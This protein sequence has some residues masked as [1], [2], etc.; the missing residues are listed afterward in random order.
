MWRDDHQPRDADDA[1]EGRARPSSTRG[2]CSCRSSRTSGPAQIEVGLYSRQVGPASCRSTARTTGDAIDPGR[3]L[4]HAAARKRTVHRLS[5]TAGTRRRSRERPG[6]EWQWS[7]K[8]GTLSFRNPKQDAL[9]PRVDQPVQAFTEPQ[10]VEIRLGDAVV[11]TFSTAGGTS[12]AAPDPADGRAA[13]A[14]GET[15]GRP[16]LGGQDLCIRRPCPPTEELGLPRARCPG[17]PRVRRAETIGLG[18]SKLAQWS[19]AAGSAPPGG[20]IVEGVYIADSE[21]RLR[22]DLEEKGLYVLSLQPRGWLSGLS[23]AGDAAAVGSADRNFSSS[24]RSWR[25]C[26][27]RGCRWS[28]SLDILR[29]RVENPTFKAVLDGVYDKVKSG[30]A[31]SDAFAEHGDLFPAGLLGVAAGGGAERQP[32]LGHPPLRRVREA[33]RR[34]PEADDLGAD[35]SGH[36]RRR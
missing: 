17:I 5:R 20:E 32:R 6:V 13:R 15:V 3:A 29:Q 2:R 27:R 25:R 9:S 4:Q 30:T 19:S 1:V 7:K 21:A 14:H 31:L 11:D 24:T 10:Q 34:G 12:R 33:H 8:Q 18:R 26:S 35:L 22:R 36:P 16:G 23:V 28:Q